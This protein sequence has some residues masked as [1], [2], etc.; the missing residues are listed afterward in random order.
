VSDWEIER[1]RER[2]RERA[3]P[4]AAGGGTGPTPLRKGE[5]R[6]GSIDNVPHLSLSLRGDI[7]QTVYN[8]PVHIHILM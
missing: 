6:R 7:K 8:S 1:E 2:E 4:S 5:S 3:S